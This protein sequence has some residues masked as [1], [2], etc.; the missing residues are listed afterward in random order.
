MRTQTL[1][2][3]PEYKRFVNDR[4]EALEKMH[5]RAQSELS[6][7]LHSWLRVVETSLYGILSMRSYGRARTVAQ[8]VHEFSH[9]VEPLL[10]G[11]IEASSK[12]N[13]KLQRMTWLLSYVGELEAVGRATGKVN[14]RAEVLSIPDP[15]MTKLRDEAWASYSKLLN[16]IKDRL[17]SALLRELPNDEAIQYVKSSFPKPVK[18]KFKKRVVR[19]VEATRKQGKDI[20]VTDFLGDG[21]WEEVISYLRQELPKSRFSD[22]VLSDDEQER[23]EWEYEQKLSDDFVTAFHNGEIPAA[24]E[25]GIQEFVWV[26]VIDNKTCETCCLPR[27]GM[28]TSEIEEAIHAGILDEDCD[29]VTPPAHPNCR[30]QIAPVGDT[31]QVEGPDWAGFNTWLNED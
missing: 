31:K 21:E 25:L 5:S 20:V 30:C 6:E 14:H 8:C 9:V 4:N 18:F 23:Y 24:N 19:A 15:D 1:W 13:S 26:S 17:T 27:N 2:E 28:T 10:F 22:D 7:V 29:A 3:S 12:I 11:A 16:K